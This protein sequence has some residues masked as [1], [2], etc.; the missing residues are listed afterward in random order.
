MICTWVASVIVLGGS[1]TTSR[2][3]LKY[4]HILAELDKSKTPNGVMMTP[5]LIIFLFCFLGSCGLNKP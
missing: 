3:K 5:K 4:K 2:C 1:K